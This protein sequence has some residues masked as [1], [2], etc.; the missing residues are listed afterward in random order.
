MASHNLQHS[1]P[2]LPT[3]GKF[4]AGVDGCKGGW[5]MVQRD[6]EGRFKKKVFESLDELPPTGIVLIDIPIGLPDSGR[7]CCDLEA[8]ENL[9]SKRCH[10]VFLD[11]RRP[12]LE[13]KSYE[14]ANKCGENDGFKISR[15]LWNILPKIREV[16]TWI[17]TRTAHDLILREGH[18]ELSFF[19]AAGQPMEHKKNKREGQKERMD[20]LARFIIDRKM[21]EDWLDQ[22]RG[23]G[24]AKDDIL[25]A[26]ALCRSAARLALGCHATLP[27]NP[28]S[29]SKGL[30]MEM[31]Y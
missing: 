15:Q 26:L 22:T 14:E 5:V 28:P 6:E 2:K 20:A 25:D 1:D 21:M 19:A 8:R 11:V 23:S 13:M 29:D 3:P 12:L 7:R 30:V 27:A 4:V 10:S 16:D 24:V 17:R 31:V 18:P 9:G